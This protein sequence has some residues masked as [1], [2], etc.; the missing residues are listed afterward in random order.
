MTG[1]GWSAGFGGD[2][3]NDSGDGFTTLDRLKSQDCVI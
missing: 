1:V 2:T 3:K